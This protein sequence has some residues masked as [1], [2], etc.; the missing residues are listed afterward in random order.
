MSVHLLHGALKTKLN[1]IVYTGGAAYWDHFGTK[2]TDNIIRM[3]TVSID[4]RKTYNII[5]TI[6]ISVDTRK[7][8]NII[9]TIK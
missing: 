8:Y 3:I 1:K 9:W 4:T 5:W 7:T 2:L 6:T